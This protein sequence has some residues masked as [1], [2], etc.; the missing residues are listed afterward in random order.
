MQELAAA[1]KAKVDQLK[2]DLA[3]APNQP[4]PGR[5]DTADKEV[6][7][8]QL[9]LVGLH[10]CFLAQQ[11]GML[12]TFLLMMSYGDLCAQINAWQLCKGKLP[13]LPA[14]P[15]ISTSLF[16]VSAICWVCRNWN[17]KVRANCVHQTVPL[18]PCGEQSLS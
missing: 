9:Y 2:A 11:R 15:Q 14:C 18:A 3:P 10:F 17:R 1:D 16:V 5:N 12:I 6:S 7:A 13:S 4:K 8:R